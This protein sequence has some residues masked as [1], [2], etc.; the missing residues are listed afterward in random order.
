M[1]KAGWAATL[2]LTTVLRA[3]QLS[4][5]LAS[6][7]G[8]IST[9]DATIVSLSPASAAIGGIG[10]TVHLKVDISDVTD[11]Y[12]FQFDL[13]FDPSILSALT[14][15]EGSFLASG[16]G[17]SFIPGTIDDLTG[18]ITFTAN[19]LSGPVSGVNGS[20]H[21][22]DIEFEALLLGTSAVTL[23]NVTLLDS[24]SA[25]IAATTTSGSVSV[26]P[27]VVPE[28]DIVWLLLIGLG[29]WLTENTVIRR[30]ALFCLGEVSNV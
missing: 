26:G 23:S 22:A 20:G 15:T 27:S 18:V 24:L 7:V 29:A 28:P 19:A 8:G 11:L 3:V 25:D 5:I 30:Y 10:G 2:G 6:F 17:T 12:A 14:I 1:N 4:A 16:G 13:S 9:V 21:L